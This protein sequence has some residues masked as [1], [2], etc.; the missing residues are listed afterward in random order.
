MTSPASMS[1]DGK[2]WTQVGTPVTI[3]MKDP[4]FIGLA[5][6][7][8]VDAVTVRTL[9]FDNVSTTGNV[10]PAGPFSGDG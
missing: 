9:T 1:A 8:H 2:T 6:T 7:S 4:V 10:I 5:V 3:A